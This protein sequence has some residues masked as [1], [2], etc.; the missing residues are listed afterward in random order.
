VKFCSCICNKH[1]LQLFRFHSN[2]P[3][4]TKMNITFDTTNFTATEARGLIA[5]LSA[6][7]GQAQPPASNPVSLA[8]SPATEEQAIFGVPTQ[9]AFADHGSFTDIEPGG[10]L[11]NDVR[12]QGQQN[13][14]RHLKRHR[15]TKAEIAADEAV[16]KAQAQPQ[17]GATDPTQSSAAPAAEGNGTAQPA[18]VPT[19]T[20]GAQPI[21]A[22]TLRSLLNAYIAR[23]SMEDAIAQLRAY[24]CNRVTEALALSADKLAQ[25]AAVLQYNG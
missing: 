3:K 13:M 10:S 22:E 16:A 4:G 18:A 14:E 23:H 6:L 8:P 1:D 19:G 5:L 9:L 12:E 11:L 20:V 7:I 17:V 2:K 15:R 24:G 21:N 25:L